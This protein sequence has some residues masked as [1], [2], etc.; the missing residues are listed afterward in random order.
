M[1][2]GVIILPCTSLLFAVSTRL[3]HISNETL[4]VQAKSKQTITGINWGDTNLYN[5]DFLMASSSQSTS[6]NKIEAKFGDVSNSS[7]R[8]DTTDDVT[9]EAAAM[10]TAPNV[11]DGAEPRRERLC[12]AFGWSLLSSLNALEYF[13]AKMAAWALGFECISNILMTCWA[14]S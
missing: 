10:A 14:R 3:L 9:P 1:T 13:S 12:R 5:K 2:R 4:A 8:F 11:R 6:G 7:I